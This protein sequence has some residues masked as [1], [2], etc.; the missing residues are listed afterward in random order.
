MSLGRYRP[1]SERNPL[2]IT[3]RRQGP[4]GQPLPRDLAHQ[5]GIRQQTPRRL[6]AREYDPTL[7]RFLSATP[8]LDPHGSAAVERLRLRQQGGIGVG[9]GAAM[10]ICVG[11]IWYEANRALSCT[12]SPV[13]KIEPYP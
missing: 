11:I 10:G 5:Q 7:G 6:D 4:F 8:L 9:C 1:A 3:K 2:A 13:L 12:S